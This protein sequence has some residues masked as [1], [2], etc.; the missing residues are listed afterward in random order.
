MVFALSD[1]S[2]ELNFLVALRA[3]SRLA[4]D[5]S[6]SS[7]F[8]PACTI[9][10]SATGAASAAGAAVA[11]NVPPALEDAEGMEEED[12]TRNGRWDGG[13]EGCTAEQW[14]GNSDACSMSSSFDCMSVGM[15][16]VAPFM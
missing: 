10:Y 16:D 15:S 8:I 12:A 4:K 6:G 9:V 3:S 1:A 13:G 2:Q 5:D 14:T 7:S 11:R